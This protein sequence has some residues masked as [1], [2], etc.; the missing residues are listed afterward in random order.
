MNDSAL[1]KKALTLYKAGKP[2]QA[3]QLLE[4]EILRFR[5][6]GTFYR[7]LGAACYAAGDY[8]G[9]DTYL[10]R[11]AQIRDRD[12]AVLTALGLIQIRRR[13]TEKALKLLLD[14]LELDP[15][16]S[17]AKKALEALRK[18]GHSDQL[19]E[20]MQSPAFQALTPDFFPGPRWSFWAPL[21][22]GLVA[23]LAVWVTLPL[24]E[25]WLSST[26][27]GMTSPP[28]EKIRPGQEGL[29]LEDVKE[30]TAFEGA[31]T[32]VMTPEEVK[33]IYSRAQSLFNS[34]RDNLAQVELNRIL[35]SNASG[36]IKGRSRTLSGLLKTP[37]FTTFQDN[38]PYAE[39]R[40]S[41]WLYQGAHVRWRGRVANKKVTESQ[42][43]FDF[44][45]GY[46]SGQVL[47]GIV[48]V[49]L[50]FA[51]LFEN[52]DGLDLLARVA[53]KDNFWNLEGVGLHKLLPE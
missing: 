50:K 46:D 31:F 26:V 15:G 40:R 25:P 53:V 3:V 32:L 43:T 11:S 51:A 34:Y 8:G 30:F 16:N 48:P 21:V 6:N 47:E 38:F 28:V 35:N 12:C 29:S 33:K 23:G 22:L 44:L 13:Q 42:I 19:P 36:E 37:D 52:G 2:S 18:Y 49:T 39:V 4:P 24:W 14:A 20:W 7:L 9:A 5:D 27:R 10:Q 41:P 45:V 17:K 1:L